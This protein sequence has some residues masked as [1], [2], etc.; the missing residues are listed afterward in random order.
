MNSCIKKLEEK[1]FLSAVSV[2]EWSEKMDLVAVG[3][4]SGEYSLFRLSW[5]KVWHCNAPSNNSGAVSSMAWRVTD[6][7]VIAVAFENI[8]H[9]MIVDI[10]TANCVHKLMLA[11]IPIRVSFGCLAH[12]LPA[13]TRGM[14]S[15]YSVFLPPLPILS[16]N[17]APDAVIYHEGVVEK[18]KILQSTAKSDK[19]NAQLDVLIVVQESFIYFYSCCLYPIFKINLGN[20]NKTLKVRLPD[21]N[22]PLL[23]MSYLNNERNL[24]L[25]WY[26]LEN[27]MNNWRDLNDQSE[28]VYNLISCFEYIST[29]VQAMLD[30]WQDALGEVQL[31]LARFSL[32]KS[33]PGTVGDEF[34]MLL[35]F[36]KPRSEFLLFLS[37]ELTSKGCDNL[38]NSI[39]SSYAVLSNLIVN[40]ILPATRAMMIHAHTLYKMFR[41]ESIIDT[42]K[43]RVV[44]KCLKT[45]GSFALKANEML[46]VMEKTQIELQSFFKWLYYMLLKLSD[47]TIPPDLSQS[48]QHE[49]IEVANF[50]KENLNETVFIENTPEGKKKRAVFRLEKVGQYLSKEDLKEPCQFH[51]KSPLA[52]FWLELFENSGFDENDVVFDPCFKSSL[53][54]VLADLEK[55]IS[56]ELANVLSASDA[57]K[58]V[59]STII[60]KS[61][62]I[63][64]TF[65]CLVDISTSDKKLYF[66][67]SD[68]SSVYLLKCNVDS[69]PNVMKTFS[70]IK[71]KT[72][73]FDYCDVKAVR[74]MGSKL[75][76]LLQ[77]M[78]DWCSYRLILV[79]IGS[80]FSELE[81]SQSWYEDENEDK[82]GRE[83]VENIDEHHLRFPE[84]GVYQDVVHFKTE[85]GS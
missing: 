42:F 81:G 4:V 59:D 39:S 69:Y 13:S 25:D 63:N 29:C 12:K 47:E 85:V 5:Q 38:R 24:V 40:H 49:L 48:S 70:S 77:E 18:A 1:G 65:S 84:F 60:A 45:V 53:R 72:D 20:V 50:I 10:N 35:L 36:G 56:V 11:E 43:S 2:A 68:K 21:E 83:K 16:K 32:E 82:R 67:Y 14:D 46:V 52:K 80:H 26:S 17:L 55:V 78:K 79:D 76:M 7:R 71:F 33:S 3:F 73:K 37:N 19:E 41:Q 34:L 8:S 9:I 27:L 51:S 58:K 62:K 61:L 66:S 44:M 22:F 74:F 6:S 54:Q 31:K 75:C 64:E 28:I 15:Q 57:A 23:S 30:S